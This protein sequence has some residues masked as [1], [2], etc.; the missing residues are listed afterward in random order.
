MAFEFPR[1]DAAKLFSPTVHI[2]DGTVHDEARFDHQLYCQ[3]P[4]GASLN[5]VQGWRESHQLA[6]EFIEVAKTKG[7][8]DAGAHCYLKSIFG[9]QPNGDIWA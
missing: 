3:I 4:E 9:L 8:V 2:H 1:A 7:L 6:G 5:G